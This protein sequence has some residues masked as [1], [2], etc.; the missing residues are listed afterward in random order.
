VKS[1]EIKLLDFVLHK[2]S[3]NELDDSGRRLVLGNCQVV[4]EFLTE[5]RIN[6]GDGE[7]HFLVFSL[8]LLSKLFEFL[9]DFA[10]SLFVED[11]KRGLLFSEN[12]VSIF[13]IESGNNRIF[14][15]LDEAL[16]KCQRNVVVFELDNFVAFV[17]I[18]EDNQS[19]FFLKSVRDKRGVVNNNEFVVLCV[20]GQNR[21]LSHVFIVSFGNQK[22]D[23][24]IFLLEIVDLFLGLGNL[25]FLVALFL[26][27]VQHGGLGSLALIIN[28][29][30]VD[31]EFECGE[32]FDLVLFREGL[33]NRAVDLCDFDFLS[34]DVE[35]GS[36]LLVIGSH[37]LAVSAPRGVELYKDE[38]FFV[39]KVFCA[40]VSENV[41]IVFQCGDLV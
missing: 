26:N 1:F 15:F 33:V 28:R 16:D 11:E 8:N 41:D 36:E 21:S 32:T 19:N 5:S 2:I 14:V 25:H 7:N 24:E 20:L 40:L 27:E 23:C 4:S 35:L 34:V 10:I 39:D 9:N 18:S 13:L 6:C 3:F 30:S 12:S 37:F 29:F 22:D 38:F 31:E 17:E